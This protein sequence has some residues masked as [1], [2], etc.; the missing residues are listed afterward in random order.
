MYYGIK[1]LSNTFATSSRQSFWYTLSVY[2]KT[3]HFPTFFKEK[4][5]ILLIFRKNQ[6]KWKAF[7]QTHQKVTKMQRSFFNN[8]HLIFKVFSRPFSNG[9]LTVF[10]SSISIQYHLK[11]WKYQFQIPN[12][13][14]Y[15]CLRKLVCYLIKVKAI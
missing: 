14:R 3:W 9:Y 2:H 12:V 4:V 1:I 6:V 13:S 5:A 7:L 10:Y 8:V 15:S 11:R